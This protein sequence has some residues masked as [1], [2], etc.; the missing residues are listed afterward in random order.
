MKISLKELKAAISFLEK[1]SDQDSISVNI[2]NE[3]SIVSTDQLGAEIQI[4]LYPTSPNGDASFLTRVRKTEL[5]PI[6]KA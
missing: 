6:P 1:N 3:F 4:M 5:L 2:H